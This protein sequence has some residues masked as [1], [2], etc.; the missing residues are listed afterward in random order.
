MKSRTISPIS[1][2]S[3]CRFAFRNGVI[4]CCKAICRIWRCVEEHWSKILNQF[5][6]I[7]HVSCNKIR[8]SGPNG[9][10][11]GPTFSHIWLT[12]PPLWFTASW[13]YCPR[14]RRG[15]RVLPWLQIWQK[16]FTQ[17][18][19]GRVP[20]NLRGHLQEP[21]AA[22]RDCNQGGDLIIKWNIVSPGSLNHFNVTVSRYW[23][24]K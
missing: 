13:M 17:C 14:R 19:T 5:F 10:R 16:N 18:R 23:V 20:S 15:L 2:P 9:Q 6:F 12:L 8:N 3:I 24:H 1:T 11:D 7:R 21:T 4:Q 22:W